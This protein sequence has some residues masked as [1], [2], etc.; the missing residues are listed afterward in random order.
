MGTFTEFAEVLLNSCTAFDQR[1]FLNKASMIAVKVH[2][3][4]NP[5][6]P[7]VMAAEYSFLYKSP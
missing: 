7:T 1:K 6:G 4:M 5:G 2:S 3:F